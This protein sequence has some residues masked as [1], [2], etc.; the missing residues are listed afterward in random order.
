MYDRIEK[1]KEGLEGVLLNG[2][3]NQIVVGSAEPDGAFKLISC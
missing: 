3:A 2:P 1:P